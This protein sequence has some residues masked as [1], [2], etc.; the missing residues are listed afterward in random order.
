MRYDIYDL[1]SAN[2]N[3]G[4]TL[5]LL[6]Q[7]KDGPINTPVPVSSRQEAE[8]IFQFGNLIDAYRQVEGVSGITVYLMRIT[9]EY[10]RLSLLG[11]VD[12]EIVPILHCRSIYG[13]EVYNHIHIYV[14]TVERNGASHPALIV[15]SPI[16]SISGLSYVLEDYENLQELVYDINHDARL[17][18]GLIYASTNYPLLDPSSLIEH[19]GTPTPMAGGD[20]GLNVTKDELY[21]ALDV[22]YSIL[23][24]RE[25]DVICPFPARF[26]DTHPVYF[27]GSSASVYGKATYASDDYLA[28]VDT[29]HPDRYV[30]FH[31]QLIDFC[32]A[33]ERFGIITHGVIGLREI[34][35]PERMQPF[36]ISRLV[37]ATAF[38]DR[39]GMVEYTDGHWIDKG[40][41]ISI[42]AQDLVFDPETEQEQVANGCAL[43]AA[44][45]ASL[46]SNETT[47]NRPLPENISLRFELTPEE[48]QDLTYLGVVTVRPSV[49]HGLVIANGVT[50]GL[51]QSDLH[52]IGNIRMVQFAMHALN[53]VLEEQ[54]GEPFVP[55]V[56]LK[57][58]DRKVSDTL[59]H[60]IQTQILKDYQYE[61][62]FE[63][64]TYTLNVSV[65][66]MPRYSTEFV[67]A[68]TSIFLG[69]YTEGAV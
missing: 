4:K 33:Q 42:F 14:G 2:L 43:Y 35:Q 38:R 6:G 34:A 19:N 48:M 18:K 26:D 53:R 61:L 7:A 13:G 67:S 66:L 47:T 58:L 60:L 16:D 51:P 3:P 62:K 10:A 45:I 63:P 17:K 36:Y 37:N 57:E 20:D 21:M 44:L 30:T 28:L 9:G 46:N 55:V 12:G 56:T 24:G 59:K 31:E 52:Y 22:S 1:P 40:H 8:R 15:E 49:K 29:E 11:E 41:Y 5:F 50:A 25:V 68:Q 23:E 54:V 27:Y 64:D 32:R 65:Y 69:N 39:Y